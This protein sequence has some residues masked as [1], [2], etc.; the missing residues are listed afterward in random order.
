MTAFSHLPSDLVKDIVLGILTQEPQ[1]S[2]SDVALVCRPWHSIVSD[3]LA[4]ILI[5]KCNGDLPGALSLALQHNQVRAF[6]VAI[7]LVS[8]STSLDDSNQALLLVSQHGRPDLVMLLLTAPH[9][10]AHADCRDGQALVNAARSGHSAVALMLLNAPQHTAHA[11]S[12]DGLALL[13]AAWGDH[14]MILKM[15]KH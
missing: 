14:H 10:T 13:E 9:H 7:E 5:H 6:N 2:I 8:T 12:Q 1:S 11:D 15:E 3:N 4:Q